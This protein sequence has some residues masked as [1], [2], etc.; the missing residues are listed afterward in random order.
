M[1]LEFTVPF[2]CPN[3][4][5]K[6]HLEKVFSGE[7]DVPLM[8]THGSTVLD[9]GANYGAFSIWATHRWPGCLV[10]AYE[11]HPETFVT[12]RENITEN[13]PNVTLHK[14][15]VGDPGMRPL[16]DGQNNPG[17]C[18]FYLQANNTGLTARH[19]EVRSPLE[20]P[21]ADVIKLDIEGCELEVLRPLIEA[22]REFDLI[23]LEWHNDYLRREVDKLLKD[24]SLIGSEVQ[25]ILGRGISKY[26]K[27]IHLEGGK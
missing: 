17:E 6:P 20:L 25:S 27:T 1:K 12:L 7:Y 16:F 11:P 21:E 14:Y 5:L 23:L 13:Y 18:S 4:Q 19:L 8:I 2:V 22:G 3:E 26:I 15:G 24:Y 9:L 10:H